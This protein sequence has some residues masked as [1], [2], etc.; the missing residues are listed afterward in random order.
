MCYQLDMVCIRRIARVIF[1]KFASPLNTDRV[2]EI[3]KVL[4][5]PLRALGRF[6]LGGP[7]RWRSRRMSSVVVALQ[8]PIRI[9]SWQAL[10]EG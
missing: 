4:D 9:G 3:H 6:G 10:L 5:T 7:D 8:S 1:W 2:F